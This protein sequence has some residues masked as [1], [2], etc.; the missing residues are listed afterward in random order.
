MPRAVLLVNT[1]VVCPPVSPVG[2]EYVG[3][4]LV[5]ASVPVRVL[6]LSF[7]TGWRACIQRELNCAEPLVVGLSVRNTDDSCFA[8]KKSYV[9]WICDIISELRKCTKAPLFLGGVGFSTMPEAVL[10]ATQADGGIE[11]DGEETMIALANSLLKG[12]DFIHLPNLV[13]RRSDSVIRNPRQ[14]VDLRSLPVPRRRIF[15]NKRYQEYGAMVGIETKRGCSQECIFCADPVAKGDRVRLRPPNM[16]VQEIQDLLEQDVSWLYF[17]DSE[18]N[19]PILHAKEICYAIIKKGL[20]DRIRWYCYCSPIPFDR[21]LVR[22]MTSAGCAGINFGIDSLCNDQMHRLGR[23]HSSSDVKRLV[24][25]LVEERVNYMFDLLIGAPGETMETIRTTI[26]KAREFDIPLVGMAVGVRVYHETPLGR[27]VANG[28][29][30]EGLFGNAANSTDDLVFYMS[31]GLGNDPVPVIHQLVGD[32]PRFL[33]L[34]APADKGSY[35]YADDEMLSRL[36]EQGA[37][38]AYW[39]IIRQHRED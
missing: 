35:N 18:F 23:A 16:V 19:I 21:E 29:L 24:E 15:D 13:Y 2:L 30:R 28:L 12:E 6:D 34:S 22:L 33:F 10:R 39:D 1:N 38:G 25:M 31:P 26:E 20:G 3:E 5:E 32:D 9:P 7:E 37:R 8:T 11:G 17:C 27:A 4:A 14:Y 36:I